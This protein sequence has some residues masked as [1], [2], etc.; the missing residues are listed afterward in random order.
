MV[1]S[2]LHPML[3][4]SFLLLCLGGV[5]VFFDGLAWWS[6][7]RLFFPK[8]APVDP[9]SWPAV[10]MLKPVA[11]LDVGARENYLSL[12]RQDYPEFQTVFVVGSPVDPVIPLIQ[13]L[14]GL[15][16][17]R[18]SLKIVEGPGG[19]NRKISNITLAMEAN[20]FPEY[21]FVLMNDSDI[22]VG[23]GYLKAIV[24]EVCQD[25]RIG[26]VTCFQRGNPSGP[27]S[28]RLASVMLNTEAIPQGLVAAALGPVDFAYGPT[29][30]MRRTALD[31]IGG[32]APIRWLL[33]DDYH[34]AQRIIAKG[35]RIALSSTIV[36]AQIP[37]QRF[38]AFWEQERRWVITYRSCRPVGYAFSLLLRPFPFLFWGAVGALLSGKGGWAMVVLF[39]WLLHLVILSD[40]S[41]RYLD[42]PLGWGAIHLL[43]KREVLS[44]AL[45]FASFGSRIVWRGR[46]FRVLRGGELLEI[47]S[48]GSSPV[49][50]ER[51]P[52]KHL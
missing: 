40:I 6:G 4:L 19:P 18:V 5:G 39:L 23:P 51:F 49:K 10:L 35:Y 48:S 47:D 3:I 32:F 27:G 38:R 45:Y 7:H 20:P 41:S 16:P 12:I 14:C 52:V 43:F 13:E 50:G 17:D 36:D 28:S 37:D 30:L 44:L 8:K 33:A 31:Q 24:R 21:P 26:L 11:G 34:L 2:P 1:L 29:M 46:S 42:R 9:P 22:R 15:Y 25:E